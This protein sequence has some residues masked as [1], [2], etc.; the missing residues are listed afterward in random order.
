[1]KNLSFKEWVI[2]LF[3]DE[4]D[5]ASVK[6]FI[7]VVGAFFLCGSLVASALTNYSPLDSLIDSVMVITAIGMGS[8][9]VD[10]F[11]RKSYRGNM[12]NYREDND[13]DNYQNRNNPPIID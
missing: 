5:N 13:D 9:T 6:P 2:D 4:S 8:D 12:R 10:K 11:S 7:A 3:K 1:M